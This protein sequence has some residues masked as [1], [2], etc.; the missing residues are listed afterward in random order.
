MPRKQPF[1]GCVINRQASTGCTNTLLAFHTINSAAKPV[2]VRLA[3]CA[4]P[5]AY[6]AATTGTAIFSR[7]GHFR[8]FCFSPRDLEF[9]D[10]DD[11]DGRFADAP[12]RRLRLRPRL[13]VVKAKPLLPI[14]LY[15]PMKSVQLL[16]K[17]AESLGRNKFHQ[18]QGVPSIT[19]AINGRSDLIGLDD[20]FDPRN[21]RARS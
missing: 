4:N 1:V 12:S 16:P 9:N 8:G 3:V 2:M 19:L 13:R 21:R 15:R 17:V 11:L 7:H 6:F 20:G 5:T 14:K 10:G 18:F